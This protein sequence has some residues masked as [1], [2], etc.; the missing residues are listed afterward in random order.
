MICPR[1]LSENRKNE[2]SQQEKPTCPNRK[3]QF[4][5]FLKTVFMSVYT[6][7]VEALRSSQ[8]SREEKR[9]IQEDRRASARRLECVL[10]VSCKFHTNTR[11]K[12]E[13]SQNLWAK[14]C[15]FLLKG[16]YCILL[17]CMRIMLRPFPQ[18]YCAVPK[19]KRALL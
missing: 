10:P 11:G 14:N 2:S 17:D 3:N 1:G 6:L 4:P 12:S 5:P 7:R 13:V 15:R 18:Q 16:V 9:L 8:I 19:F